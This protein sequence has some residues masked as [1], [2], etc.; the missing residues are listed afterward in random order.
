MRNVDEKFFYEYMNAN[1]PTGYEET[2]QYIW[3][4][5][6]KQYVDETVTDAYGNCYGIIN[7]GKEF[8]VVIE[9][10][11]DEI[12]W[13]V[14]YI[15]PEGYIYVKPNGGSDY[16]IAPGMRG[17]IHLDDGSKLP[18]VFGWSPVHIKSGGKQEP[19]IPK[20]DNVVLDCGCNS[21]KEVLEQGIHVGSIITFDVNLQPLNN[22]KY[23]V[24]RA[25]DNRSGGVTIA[26]VAKKIKEKNEHLPFSLYICNCVQEEVGL[27]GA[28]M[29]A[30]RIKPHLAICTDVCHDTQSP[31][32]NKIKHGNISCGRGAV[33]PYSPSIHRNLAAL[34]RST[35]RKH[36]ISIQEEFC[37]RTSGTDTDAFAY[38]QEGIPSALVSLP[39]KYMHTTVEMISSEDLDNVIDLMYLTLKEITPDFN[40]SYF[41]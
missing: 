20:I 41:K 21:D 3:M 9:A 17:L 8:K 23:Y 4:E 40:S 11:A 39:L 12:S 19:Q 2:G 1:A 30:H 38:C 13:A 18:A 7:P 35:A 33:I 25:F 14:N 5:Y 24:C 15:S 37:A 29:L 32:Y 10:H 26:S 28:S 27:H 6:I 16:E 31:F 36:N 22:G 34:I